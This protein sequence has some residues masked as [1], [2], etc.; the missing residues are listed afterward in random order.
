MTMAAT[1]RIGFAQQSE[2]RAPGAPTVA[3]NP[4]LAVAA[5]VNGLAALLFF[6]GVYFLPVFF[7]QVKGTES[8]AV[9]VDAPFTCWKN[10]GGGSTRPGEEG[11]PTGN[12]W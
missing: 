3:Q 7:Q 2:R 12:G 11:A 4:I 10:S 1:A 8:H 6:L 9:G 5:I